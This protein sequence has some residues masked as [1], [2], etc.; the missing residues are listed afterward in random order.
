MTLKGAM[1]ATL[2][3]PTGDNDILHVSNINY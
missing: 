1:A 3:P 2:G